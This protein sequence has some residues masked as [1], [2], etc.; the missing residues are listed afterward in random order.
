MSVEHSPHH[1]EQG[2]EHQSSLEQ[3]AQ[4]RREELKANPEQ[5]AEQSPD[6]RAEAAREIIHKSTEVQPN[7]EPA[8]AAE[9]PSL[10]HRLPVF[11]PDVNY[12]HTMAS[13]QH[14]L[15][16][17]SRRFSRLIHT[18]AIE[19]TSEALEKTVARPSVINGA[20][21]TALLVGGTFYIIARTYGYALS[22]SEI[23]FSFLAGGLIGIAAESLWR[24]FHH[25]DR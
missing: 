3:A 22:G 8:N 25:S 15:A 19:K 14:K 17:V 18:P 16:P 7:P 2:S 20:L 23:L 6:R 21:W 5:T 24:A 1:P 4:E 9:K 11:N 13:L 10:R 12:A